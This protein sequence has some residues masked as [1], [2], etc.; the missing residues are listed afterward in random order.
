[1]SLRSRMGACAM[2][3]SGIL[4]ALAAADF[5]RLEVDIK[6]GIEA[7]KPA[8]GFDLNLVVCN[9]YVVFDHPGDNGPGG[10]SRRRGGGAWAGEALSRGPPPRLEAATIAAALG[11]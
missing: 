6:D 3:V 7:C 10:S 8:G 5:V 4:P 1:M 2:L 11:V 9:F